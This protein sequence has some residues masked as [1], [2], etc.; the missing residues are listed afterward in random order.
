MKEGKEKDEEEEDDSGFAPDDISSAR[1]DV[2]FDGARTNL[3]LRVATELDDP[4]E[5]ATFAKE[6]QEGITGS[7]ALLQM[8]LSMKP[9]FAFA[10]PILQTLE[11]RSSGNT[12]AA[13]LAIP[14]SALESI[15]CRKLAEAA[16]EAK[17]NA[18][19]L[20]FAIPGVGG[21][22]ADDNIFE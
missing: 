7:M 14:Y 9:E 3:F 6:A 11:V 18:P 1:L 21:G 13:G 19:A 12:L 2:G 15:D 10:G 20:P 4:E 5:A 22:D 17:K 16:A 8:I